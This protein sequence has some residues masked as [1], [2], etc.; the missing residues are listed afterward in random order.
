[1]EE[2]LIAMKR[3]ETLTRKSG[4]ARVECRAGALWVTG[5]GI[6]E[7][8]ILMEGESRDVSGLRHVCVQAL[9]DAKLRVF[10]R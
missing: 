10:E 3:N 4:M 7:D 9:R 8:L 1:M 2:R 5:E 6:A